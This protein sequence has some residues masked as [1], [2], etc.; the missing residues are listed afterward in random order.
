MALL[1][2]DVDH[3]KKINDTLGHACGDVLLREFAQRLRKPVRATDSVARLGGDEFAIIMEGLDSRESAGAVADK[4]LAAVAA[5]FDLD[6][7]PAD[8]STSIG[9]AFFTDADIDGK[10][11]LQ[12][13]DEALYLSKAGGHNRYT[14]FG[15]ALV[16]TSV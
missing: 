14:V 12:Q 4:I 6:G 10:R 2:L 3:F 7:R 15:Q 11:Y 13:S 9:I 5:P 1:Y 16:A 8:V